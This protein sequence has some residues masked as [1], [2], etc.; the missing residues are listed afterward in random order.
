MHKQTRKKKS[1]VIMRIMKTTKAIC[2]MRKRQRKE[3]KL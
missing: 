1:L 2:S 3:T